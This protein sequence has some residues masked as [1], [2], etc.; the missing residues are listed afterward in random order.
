MK[1]LIK[2]SSAF[3]VLQSIP[4]KP[5]FIEPMILLLVIIPS[6]AD[7]MLSFKKKIL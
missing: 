1:S 2:I 7:N 3:Y 5:A 4:H 6:F